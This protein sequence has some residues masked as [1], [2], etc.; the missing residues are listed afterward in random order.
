MISFK[1]FL[2][3]TVLEKEIVQ[4][5]EKYRMWN[6]FHGLAPSEKTEY[7]G[8]MIQNGKYYL[9]YNPHNLRKIFA[10]NALEAIVYHEYLHVVL[11]H[12]RRME[13]IQ[14]K[15]EKYR[16][17]WKFLNALADLCVNQYIPDEI[18]QKISDEEF[19][20]AFRY[21]WNRVIVPY[22]SLEEYASL[23]APSPVTIKKEN[24]KETTELY[25]QIF[26]LPQQ[27][28]FI[29]TNQNNL[30][31]VH[32]G[33]G[34]AE[35][36]SPLGMA[37]NEFLQTLP[38]HKFQK[39]MDDIRFVKTMV[40]KMPLG[41][42]LFHEGDLKFGSYRTYKKIHRK[43]E[44]LPGKDK[45][46][47]KPMVILL[48]DQSAS[49]YWMGMEKL[50]DFYKLQLSFNKK[51]ETIV[52]PFTHE[53]CEEKYYN[54]G[55]MTF[56]DLFPKY[57]GGTDVF[58]ALDA[59]MDKY[60]EEAFYVI[61]SDFETKDPTNKRYLNRN[62]YYCLYAGAYAHSNKQ[63]LEKWGIPNNKIYVHL[64]LEQA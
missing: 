30:Q 38:Q 18:I 3:K 28:N 4:F 44:D 47:K 10:I 37:S 15:H 13:K 29:K 27:P 40:R 48:V 21:N 56:E 54:I 6:V 60:G 35:G 59:M 42:K 53:I 58:G 46:K 57:R 61:L 17:N 49:V 22:L 8:T 16:E 9:I 2:P 45:R 19:R 64:Y 24:G 51:Y 11:D 23:F 43:N 1:A 41:E 36:I 34:L 12:P 5:M 25:K 63:F 62:V 31:L 39:F 33:D 50:I 26:I 32:K 7:M 55:E 14:E 20:A 52:A